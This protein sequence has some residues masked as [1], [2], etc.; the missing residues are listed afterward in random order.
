[1]C[2]SWSP[3]I[4]LLL[5]NPLLLLASGITWHDMTWHDMHMHNALLLSAKQYRWNNNKNCCFCMRICV[6]QFLKNPACKGCPIIICI[7]YWYNIHSRC[8]YVIFILVCSYQTNNKDCCVRICCVSFFVYYY[9][10]LHWDSW[11]TTMMGVSLIHSLLFHVDIPLLPCGHNIF[12]FHQPNCARMLQVKFVLRIRDNTIGGI[13][14]LTS[15]IKPLL[16]H[17]GYIN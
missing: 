6:A 2:T 4:L 8:M 11:M 7:K 14:L 1:M 9:V 13:S 15:I 16:L 17:T 3:I 12:C 5:V 10:R